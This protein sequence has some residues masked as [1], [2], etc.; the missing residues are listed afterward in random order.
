MWDWFVGA[1]RDHP[2][3]AIFLTM[4]LGFFIGRLSFKSLTLGAV[5]GTL[6]AGVVVGQLGI[7]IPDLVKT[8]AFIGFLFALG[9]RVGP[10]FFAALTKDGVPQMIISVVGCVVGL[11]VATW[12][13]SPAPRRTSPRSR[14]GSASAW[15]RA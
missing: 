5:T 1:M 13:G 11:L 8:V 10:Q 3:L 9:Y 15:T 4:A 12:S 6:L 14:R 2:E 7:Q